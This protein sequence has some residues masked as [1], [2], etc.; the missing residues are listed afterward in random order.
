MSDSKFSDLE[1]GDI[2][3]MSEYG[4]SEIFEKLENFNWARIL[5]S[6]VG[7]KGSYQVSSFADVV[8]IKKYGTDAYGQPLKINSGGEK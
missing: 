5:H 6:E 7:D 2:F 3:Y 8:L 4:P 1:A